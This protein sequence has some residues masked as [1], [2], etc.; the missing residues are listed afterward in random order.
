[1]TLVAPPTQVSFCTPIQWN[2]SS[3]IG[4]VENY[5]SFKGTVA[6]VI[7][8]V[9]TVNGSVLTKEEPN[10]SGFCATMIKIIT[11]ILSAGVLAL[12]A[13]VIKAIYRGTH[14]FHL[15][16]QQMPVPTPMIKFVEVQLAHNCT[17]QQTLTVG[18][19]MKTAYEK[20]V[21]HSR[22]PL[23]ESF[24][25]LASHGGHDLV[26]NGQMTFF[27]L[28]NAWKENLGEDPEIVLCAEHYMNFLSV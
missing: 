2:D 11:M 26:R 20:G 8:P 1:M 6:R 7:E 13:L 14:Q 9:R 15:I 22:L 17:E 28:W 16:S 12:L 5:L 4:L 25:Y 19:M 24:Q 23:P 10:Q 27:Q 21:V 18:E 3:F